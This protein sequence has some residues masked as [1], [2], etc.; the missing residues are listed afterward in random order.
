[1]LLSA[2]SFPI[3]PMLNCPPS[4]YAHGLRSPSTFVRQKFSHI[5][6][7][8]FSSI[9]RCSWTKVTKCFCPPKVLPMAVASA[10]WDYPE[11][12]AHAKRF[13]HKSHVKRVT[14]LSSLNGKR[15]CAHV[16]PEGAGGG[17]RALGPLRDGRRQWV[18]VA[19]HPLHL[20]HIVVG[21]DVG[22]VCMRT[23]HRCVH[24]WG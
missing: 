21:W 9:Y 4:T 10:L 8:K 7:V 16:H 17:K 5:S 2:K 20:P 18:A 24:T 13:L 12:I 6:H 19:E 3:Y 15:T 1:V 11:C 22:G 14:Y 23:H